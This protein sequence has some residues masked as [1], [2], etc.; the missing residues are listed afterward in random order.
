MYLALHPGMMFDGYDV[1][2]TDVLMKYTWLGDADLS[3]LIDGNDYFQIDQGYAGQLTGYLNGDFNYDGRIDADDYFLID[4]NYAR[5]TT[6][7]G[8]ISPVPEPASVVFA[9]LAILPFARRAKKTSR[10]A[11]NNL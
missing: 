7:L 11:G 1:D 5:Q 4:S 2:P 9:G 10:P 8:G 3:G 6:M